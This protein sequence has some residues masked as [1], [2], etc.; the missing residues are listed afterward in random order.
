[1][2]AILIVGSGTSIG[3]QGEIIE[4]GGAVICVPFEIIHDSIT[5]MQLFTSKFFDGIPLKI[6]QLTMIEDDEESYCPQ[7][8]QQSLLW[9]YDPKMIHDLIVRL[10]PTGI[11][12]ILFHR[13]CFMQ[14]KEFVNF[15]FGD[16]G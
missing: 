16:R 11:K 10:A 13:K 12:A 5:E 9:R 8:G 4:A 3:I 1:M 7:W 15:R 6:E 14:L 2:T